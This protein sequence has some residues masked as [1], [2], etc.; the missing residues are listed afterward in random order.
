MDV[1]CEGPGKFFVLAAGVPKVRGG[2][3]V[4][5]GIIVS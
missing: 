3:E 5:F 1:I 4:S 2:A